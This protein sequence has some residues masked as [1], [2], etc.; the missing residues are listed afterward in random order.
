MNLCDDEIEDDSEIVSED[1]NEESEEENEDS[2][3]KLV[4]KPNT[5][6]AVF[7]Q[8]RTRWSPYTR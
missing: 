4:S 7:Y 3:E 8:S 1:N 2:A 5:K 6:S